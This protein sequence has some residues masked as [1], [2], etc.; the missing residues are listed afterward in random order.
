M[1]LNREHIIKALECHADESNS[2]EICPYFSV[3][4]SLR[5]SSHAV[6]L[7][8]Q[9]TEEKD[10]YKRYYFNHE[11]DKMEADIKADTVRKMQERLHERFKSD[12]NLVYSNYNIHR[13]IDQI[14]KGMLEGK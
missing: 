6:L 13:Y 4:C 14:A 5:M 12:P 1:E 10:R 7:I 2:C 11:Y 3:G 9:L 8:K